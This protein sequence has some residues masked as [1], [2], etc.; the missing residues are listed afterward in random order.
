MSD[1]FDQASELEEKERTNLI[2]QAR[3]PVPAGLAPYG[4]CHFCLA[5]LGDDVRR[6]CDGD[7]ATDHERERAAKLRNGRKT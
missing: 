3:R 2:A 6:F 1:V 7:C 4:K 5:P